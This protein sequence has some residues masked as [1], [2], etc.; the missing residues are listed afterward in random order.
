MNSF[1][2]LLCIAIFIVVLRLVRDT[3][4]TRLNA[5][6]FDHFDDYAD[7]SEIIVPMQLRK[8]QLVR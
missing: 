4:I 7:R 3:Y 1:I 6:I 5:R 8:K 2:L